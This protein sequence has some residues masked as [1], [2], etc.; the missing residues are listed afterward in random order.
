MTA[1]IETNN[2]GLSIMTT[3]RSYGI[4][5]VFGIPGTHNLEFYRHLAPLGIRAVTTRHEQGAGYGADGWSQLS[6][7]PG[8]VITTSGPGLLNALAAAATAYC[9]SRPLLLLSPGAPTGTEFSDVGA[10]HETKDPTGAVGAIVQQSTRATSGRHAVRLVHEAFELFACGRPRPVHIEV[11]LDILESATDCAAQDC[12]ARAPR[13]PQQADPA[14]VARAAEVLAAAANPVILAG[15]G[16]LKAGSTLLA[17]AERL[18]APVVTTINGKGAIPERHGLSLGSNIRFAA[19]QQACN[20]ADALLIVGS[21]VG[22]SELWGGK[23][24]PQGS[25]IRVDIDPG[26]LHTNV[27]ADIG[28]AGDAVAVLPQLAEAVAGLPAADRGPAAATVRGLKQALLAE[29]RSQAPELAEINEVLAAVL[30][31]DA[32]I[33]GDSSQVTYLGT[34]SFFPMDQPHQLLYTPA[35]ATLG[36]GLAAAIGAKL[37]DPARTVVGLIGDGALMFAI[38]ELMTAVEQRLDLP[39]ICVDNGGY[40]EIRQNMADRNLPPVGVDLVQPDWAL[41]A[42]GFGASGFTAGSVQDLAATLE[43]ALA[44]S[45]PSLIHLRV[46]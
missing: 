9:E 28:L 25:C 24:A 45:G 22:E 30:P 15:G 33:A 11:P 19:A 13:A 44:V 3:L 27:T 46:A 10:L 20:G 41:L 18:Q 5:T 34:A 31:H 42:E 7:L 43:K 38:Q 21:K 23:L 37:A 12:R 16:S 29:A 17:L 39:I 26:Q 36:Y 32:V 1:G 4:D 35:Y 14:A 40:G 6:G 2:V 8:V